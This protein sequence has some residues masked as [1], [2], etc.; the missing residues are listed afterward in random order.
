MADSLY[1]CNNCIYTFYTS[2]HVI[3][4]LSPTIYM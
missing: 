2:I 4:I 3:L 1:R